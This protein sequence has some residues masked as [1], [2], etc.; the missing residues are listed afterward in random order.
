MAKKESTSEANNAP[1]LRS[2]RTHSGRLSKPDQGF[3]FIQNP[4]GLQMGAKYGVRRL[5]AAFLVG[6]SFSCEKSVL[7]GFRKSAD[8]S[9]HNKALTS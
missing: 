7:T 9:A 6:R 5:V 1:Y 4:S 3:I 8:E 2:I